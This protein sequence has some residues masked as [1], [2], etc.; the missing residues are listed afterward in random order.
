M[1][2]FRYHIVSIV[3]VFLALALGIVIGTTAL[4]GPVTSDLR[5]QVDNLKSDN[6]AYAEKVKALNEQVDDAG[7]FASTFGAR[8]VSGTLEETK[9]LIL[10]L[11]GSSTGM[12]DGIAKQIAAAGGKITSRL[13]L[14]PAYVDPSHS[15]SIVALATGEAYPIDLPALP[16]TN[17]AGQLGGA[18]LAP[19]LVGKGQPTD[20][21]QVLSGFAEIH[22]ISVDPKSVEPAKNVVVIGSGSLPKDDYGGN[23]ELDLI[24]A[25]EK[26]GANVVVAGDAE[27]ATK[28]GIVARVRESATKNSVSTVD[29]AGGPF[30]KISTVLALAASIDSHVGQYGTGPGADALFPT[31]R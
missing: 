5:N 29:N 9:V 15:S 21:V 31:P 10:G 13:D 19:V 24:K 22:M 16:V 2:S 4:S 27:S 6:S 7:Q 12:Q 28:G 30:G 8:L 11:P 26:A 18:L 14:A 1:I 3:G 17:D 25:L 23:V 20:L